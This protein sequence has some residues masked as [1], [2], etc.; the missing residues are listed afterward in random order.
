LNVS[1]HYISA[2]GVAASRE[3]VKNSF[4]TGADFEEFPIRRDDLALYFE[5]RF[6]AGG[7]FFLNAG[8]RGEFLRTGAIRADAFSRPAIPENTVSSVNPRLS[9]ALLPAAGTRLHA[10]FATGI[11]P[12]TGFELA[13]TNNPSLSPERTRSFEAGVE[14]RFFGRILVDATWFYNRYTDLIVTLGGTLS[15][16]SRYQSANIANS[17]AQGLELSGNVRPSRRLLVT[18]SYTLLATRIL[19]LEGSRGLAPAPFQVGQPLTRRPRNSGSFVA[20]YTRGRI[21]ADFTGYFRGRTLFEEPG[22]GASNG[23]FW[24]PGYSNLG[25]NL[26]ITVLPGV[27]AYGN[28]RNALNRR[29]EEVFG[30]PA[31]R[32]NFVAGMK[33]RIP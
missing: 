3:Q 30:Y 26:N 8:V 20:T 7:R 4:V 31:P 23:L 33:W 18:G 2:F 12:P 27:T 14:Q 21:A 9:A 22:F 6:E 5:N 28:L 1:P 29:Y 16:L 17:R 24:N 11:R 15:S 10:S 13:F 25:V 19:S 32:L